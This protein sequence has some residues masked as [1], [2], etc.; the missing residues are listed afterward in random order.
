[1]K[2]LLTIIG[3]ALSAV[4]AIS[5][6]ELTAT[7]ADDSLNLDEVVVVGFSQS[8]KANLTGSVAQVTMKD[9]L[10]DRPIISVGAALQGMIPGL[11]I[12]GVSSPGQ[13]KNFNIR[14][15]LSLNGGSPLI[16]I[17]NAEGNLFNLNP[18]DI[19]SITVLKDAASAA[20]YGARAAGGVVLVTTKRPKG[21][22]DF[23]LDYSFNVG[24]E[25]R[26]SNPQ[27]ASLDQYLDAYQEAGFS[28]K[29]WA[30]N[31]DITRW[32]ELLSQFRQGTLQGAY[33]NGI[34]K[35]SDG[36]VYFLQE[37]DVLG[38]A[39]ETGVLN[40][41]R[42]SV[43]GGTDRLRYR[44]SGNYSHEDGP[45]VSNKDALTRKTLNA[46]LSAD[47][48]RWFTQEASV[49]YTAQN[50][51]SIMNVFRDVYSIRLPSWYPEGYMP[52]EVVGST[53]DLLIDSPRNA[54]LY[55]PADKKQT[56]TPRISLRSIIKPLKGWTITGE[57]T[58][59][60]EDM[61]Y[62]SYTGRYTVADAQLAIRTLP[63]EGQDVY[64]KNSSTTKYNALNL[65]TN[66][67]VKW[68][69]HSFSLVAGFNQEYNFSTY[70]N[71]Q[72]LGQTV[73]SVPSVQGGTG[74]KTLVEGTSEYAIRS[75]F[76]RLAYNYLGRYLVE[77]NCR[78]DGSSKFPKNN[79]FGFFPSVSGA[80]RISNE[81]FMEWANDWLD[82][83]KVRASYGSI[84]NQN[85]APYG[86]IAGMGISQSSVWLDKQQLVNIISTPGLIRANYT[87]ETVNTFDIGIDLNLLRNRMSMTF[88]WYSR[89]TTGMLGNGVELPSVVGAAAPLQNVSDMKT[90]GWELSLNWHDNIGDVSYRVGFN[91][92][93]HK[94]KITKF[95][96]ASGNL[97][98][99]YVGQVLGEIW[100]YKADGYYS[101]ED[102][103]LDQA[104]K[105]KWILKEGVTSINGTNPKPGDVK[106]LDLDGDG[107][108]TTGENT[109]DKPGDRKIIGN[110]TARYEFGANLSVSWRGLDLSM[111]L[112]GVGK[113]DVVLSGAALYP[114]AANKSE[115]AFLPLY[116][117][118]TDYWTAKSYDPESPD[119]MVAANPDAKLFRIYG[120]LDNVG[121]NTRTSDM[122]LQ[123]GAYMRIKNV[124][125][126]YS[127]PTQWLKATRVIS[128]V[129]L[130][131]SGENLATFTS[132]PKGYD[133]ESL[134]WSYPFYR[135][136][137]FGA[138]VTF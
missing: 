112:Q 94:S 91:L 117:N 38:N 62:R 108:I 24:F 18:D 55:Q 65:F 102:F 76:G 34:Y 22:Q 64:K 13:P 103:D 90:R 44:I 39:L 10:G 9:V 29:Y 123:N 84:G 59:Q 87:W 80:W 67:D 7:Q 61:D 129:R 78:Y 107:I 121:S 1:M 113:R 115:G 104:R 82:N 19:E 106:F 3:V 127:L 118:Q 37:S 20:I 74:E 16:L 122:Y 42:V 72:V 120:Q 126:S 101:I 135:T 12:S 33:S 11:S 49:F 8:K 14:G 28:S 32:R 56:S 63:A 60:Q 124:T 125:L 99:R 58:Y 81:K 73:S 105:D 92:Y 88:D 57:Y 98:S 25:T 30:G 40:N 138:N 130:Y 35:D 51:S 77:V 43:S 133:P 70:L 128:K 53:E 17:D 85:I 131:V 46:Y 93:D 136:I 109:L 23:H 54:C 86:Y 41:Q 68:K 4:T 47:V 114:F 111:V 89:E 134:S 26:I 75:A 52:A 83:F 97:G 66:Y 31:G 69:G 36:A 21:K 132:L 2:K 27:Y 15:T 116:S 96:N 110:S 119:Y 5:A 100:G 71:T 48:N 50:R 95:N 79:R 6:Q 45:M 137:S